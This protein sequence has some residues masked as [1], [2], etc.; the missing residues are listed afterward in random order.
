M[1]IE[2]APNRIELSA[3]TGGFT[4]DPIEAAIAP[5][6][7][8]AMTNLLPMPWGNELRLR[9]GFTREFATA[10]LSTLAATHWLRH[11]WYYELIDSSARKKYLMCLLTTGVNNVANNVQLWAL[12]LVNNSAARVDTAGV[13]WAKASVEAWG[14]TIEGT[15]YMG[16]RA[17][18][19]V[20]WHPTAGYDATPTT[21]TANT[22]V[23]SIAPSSGETARDYAY[24]K[25]DVVLYSAKYYRAARSIRY[26]KWESGQGYT[27]GERVSRKTAIGGATYWRSYECILS[28][29]A[30]AADAPGTGANTDTYWKKR[31]LDNVLDDDSEINNDWF[32]NPIPRKASVGAY[33]GN[34][35]W[36]R[37]DDNDNWA[38]LQYSAPAKPER[39]AEIADLDFD[40]TDWAAVDDNDGDGGGWLTIPFSG[41]GDAIRA[42]YSYGN[43]LIIAGRWQTY[44]LSGLNESTWTLRKLGNYGA[45]SL[46]CVTELDGL[47]YMLGRHGV[48]TVTDGTA[49][50]PVPGMEKI[51]KWLK[52]KLDDVL[53]ASSPASGANWFPN[54]TAHDGFLFIS[55]PNETTPTQAASR[56]LVYD[57]RSASF[58]DLD[59]PML[60][61]TTGEDG[62]VERLWF[63]TVITKLTTQTPTVFRYLDDPGAE[64]YTDDDWQGLSGSVATSDISWDWRSSWFQFGMTRNERRLRKAWALVTGEAASTV[65]V[66]LFYNF[67]NGASSYMTTTTRTL[68]GRSTRQGEFVEALVGQGS[69]AVFAASIKLS[70]TANDLVAVHGV[71]IDTEP[72][73]SGRFHK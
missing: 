48:L 58:W 15:F 55:L 45:A 57:P 42:L 11:M 31:R 29:S 65:V 4:P 60:D 47:V 18:A 8:P 23:D 39:D 22:W 35:L 68:T 54:L 19:P 70:G 43:Y 12:D 20:S 1:P 17:S 34:R 5:D 10:R 62:G 38:R 71:G 25:G 44:V 9:N 21:P 36:V 30:T 52:D 50:Q 73:R 24:K 69:P 27:S 53:G 6:G 72:L 41:K 61:M 51:R 46:S 3:L 28:H 66:R 63:S 56:T 64:V 26:K 59:I 7:S 40:P 67:I 13:A 32:F 33:H 14:A 37:A 16:I 2:V 49:M